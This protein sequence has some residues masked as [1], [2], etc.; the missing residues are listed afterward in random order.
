MYARA[1]S[2]VAAACGCLVLVALTGGVSSVAAQQAATLTGRVVHST[3]KEPLAE[4][5]V[6]LEEL[7]QEVKSSPDGTYRFESVPPGTYHLTVRTN[8][9]VPKRE[10]IT[11]PATGL[12]RDLELD[13]ELHF[14]EVVSV[15]PEPRNQFESYQ[16]TTVLAGVDLARQLQG[17]LGASLE[18]QPGLAMRSFGPGPAR[19]V[20]RGLDGDRVLILEDGQRMGDLSSQSAD[21]GVT[22]NPAAA[23]RVEVVRGPA[24]LLYGSNAIGGLVNVINETVPVQPIRG[25]TGSVVLDGGTAASEG[26]GAADVSWGNGTWAA[27]FGGGGRGSGDVDTPEGTIDNSQSRSGMGSAAL[28]WTSQRGYLGGS[29]GYEDTKYGIPIVESGNIQLT[30][31]RH[32]FSLRGERHD[33]SGPFTTVRASLGVRRYKHEELDGDEIGT[34]FTNNTTEVEA[35]LRHRAAGALQGTIGFW[36][37]ARAFSAAGAEAL[38]PPVDQSGFAAFL[39]E[40]VTQ[41]HMTFQF[42]GRVERAAFSPEGGLPDRD[43]TNFSGSVGLLVRPTETTTIAFSVA[44]AA[45]NPALE[46]L[47][48]NGPHPGNFAFEIGNPELESE[49]A[50]G[51]DASFRWR[52]SRASGEVTYFFNDV[53]DYIFRLP[54]G[55]IEEDFPVV[56]FV[57]ADARLQGIEG[58]LDAQLGA[59]LSLELG[60]DYVRGDLTSSDESLPRIPPLRVRSGLRY[61]R[62]G[63]QLGGEVVSAA[64]Q[65]RVYSTETP[66]DGYNLLKLFASYTFMTGRSVSTLT[67][68]LD[69]TTNE[70][71]RNHLSYIKDFVPEMGRNFKV[72]Y[73]V[74]F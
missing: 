31:R 44:R 8:G 61:Q 37:L 3:T 32:I 56:E 16:P 33:L 42:G 49:K 65:D 19:P 28:S 47:Y 41:P 14:S 45:R 24:S 36:G 9:F 20:I 13:P 57:A 72:I 74:R 18:T 35:Q 23:S 60:L 30:P 68:R 59:G 62:N 66:T 10:E 26:G 69:N 53:N 6:V 17:T 63:F 54:T 27:R 43:F 39:Y 73:A 40:E 64:K 46:E 50:V 5:L 55:E 21:H 1:F 29:Y 70:L 67:I 12:V 2:R 4:G 34:A 71:Y 48:F 11:I 38:S 22:T 58:H 25:A 51:F 7:K 52:L 15:S